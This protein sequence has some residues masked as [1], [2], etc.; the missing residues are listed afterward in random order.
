MVSQVPKGD[1]YSVSKRQMLASID[2]ALAGRCAEQLI[3]G[4]DDTTTGASSDLE[5]ATSIARHMVE[6]C[7]M[8][9]LGPVAL[10]GR[11]SRNAAPSTRAAVDA[12]VLRILSEASRRVAA[13]MR[14]NEPALHSLAKALLE[15]ET[16]NSE[17]IAS[18]VAGAGSKVAAA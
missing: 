11:A 8:S 15:Q 9:E 10:G 5:A 4:E 13:L 16:M 3:F 17:Q 1:E 12:A 7:G 18:C 2:V 6:D 14:S